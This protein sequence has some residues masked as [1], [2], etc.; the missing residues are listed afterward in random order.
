[1][2]EQRQQYDRHA[3]DA[4]RIADIIDNKLNELKQ[5]GKTMSSKSWVKKLMQNTNVYDQE[6][7]LMKMIEIRKDLDNDV[8]S[9]GILSFGMVIFP[10]KQWILSS[11]GNFQ[12]EDFFSHVAVFDPNTQQ[13]IQKSVMNNNDFKILQPTALKLWDSPKRVT[14]VL[15]SLEVVNRP[16][17]VLILF[18]D[19]A[20]FSDYMHRFAGSEFKELSITTHQT[21][22]YQQIQPSSGEQS[23]S[24]KGYTLAMPS[25]TSEWQYAVTY[26]DS[27]GVWIHNLF[28]S[29]LAILI[30][31]AV[32]TCSAFMLTRITYR[33]LHALLNKLSDRVRYDDVRPGAGTGS[34]YNYIENSI[35]RLLLENQELQQSM[36][37]FESAAR[38]NMFLRLLK[39]YFPEDPQINGLAK[40][41]IRYTENMSYCTMLISLHA[42][43]EMTDIGKI[44]KIEMITMLVVEKVLQHYQLDH[45]L[46]EISNADK[47]LIVSSEHP[48]GADG[49]IERIASEIAAEIAQNSGFHLDVL[50]GPVEQGLVGISKSYYAAHEQLQYLLF[51][52]GHIRT[53]QEEVV[54]NEVD[55]YYPTDW[56]VQL[57]NN[58]KVGNLDTS[59][60]ILQEINS[61]NERRQL[62]DSSTVRLVSLLMETMLRVLHEVNLDTGIYARQFASMLSAGSILAM[63]S[64]VYEVGTLICERN[65]YSNTS[66]TMEVGSK[67]LQYVNE[68]YTSADVSLKKLAEMYQM[69]TS[70]VSKIFKEVSGINFYD[71]LCRLRMEMAKELLR[72]KK[73][74]MD[75]IALR[76]GYENVYSFKR[77]FTRYEG[78][79]PDEY[80]QMAI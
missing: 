27:S 69:S 62:S 74:A 51:S 24:E 23:A 28:S 35:D 8:N 14:P 20:Y 15:Q 16:R 50:H 5:F 7:D 49:L 4:R 56:E 76:V 9:I 55:Y 57:I 26:T 63:W 47:A 21:S 70:N 44:R 1:M 53:L 13:A 38:S 32:G 65:R 3:S 64:Y 59:M 12:A 33:P 40:F 54:P 77:A 73:C 37:A 6:F 36:L 29:L 2:E 60:Q 71:Y 17:A 25:K 46:F 10:E 80:M 30:S 31:I 18:I 58:L 78:I 52:R 45:E 39:G 43:H 67:L 72:E 61:E 41:G 75:A 11:I 22:I 79:K 66:S 68:N 48:F 34:E 42:I 19:S